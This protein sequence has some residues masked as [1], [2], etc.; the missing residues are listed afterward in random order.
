MYDFICHRN[1]SKNIPL[2]MY[3]STKKID[4]KLLWTT[5]LPLCLLG[6]PTP[7][8]PR[9][10]HPIRYPA[11]SCIPRFD[12]GDSVARKPKTPKRYCGATKIAWAASASLGTLSATKELKAPPWIFTKTGF[13][14]GDIGALIFM[15]R[16]SSVNC[17]TRNIAF[18]FSACQ[19][20]RFF[21]K[22][23]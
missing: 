16:Q 13:R 19:H 15:T 10:F 11:W 9:C 17:F 2:D 4:Y 7:R 1:R 5:L 3:N 20:G 21:S 6:G 18:I 23:L 8:H 12:G 22:A 14:P